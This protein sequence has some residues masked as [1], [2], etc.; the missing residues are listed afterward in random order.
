MP[1]VF[2]AVKRPR[3][4]PVHLGIFDSAFLEGKNADCRNA[5]HHQNV[6]TSA[7]SD[8]EKQRPLTNGDRCMQALFPSPELTLEH[9]QRSQPHLVRKNLR[10]GDTYA[11]YL[12]KCL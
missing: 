1:P 7:A 2:V 12:V 11:F 3:Y 10:D 9:T 8:D 6:N 5:R 4:L